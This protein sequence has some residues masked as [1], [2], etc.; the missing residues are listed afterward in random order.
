MTSRRES[1]TREG[2]PRTPVGARGVAPRRGLGLY[3]NQAG[4]TSE[5]AGMKVTRSR[6]PIIT[7]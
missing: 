3:P 5:I 4:T 7:Q 1:S 2:S 6:T